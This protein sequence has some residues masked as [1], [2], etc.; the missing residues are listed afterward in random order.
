MR[1]NKA[2]LSFS[3]FAITDS[4]YRSV[5]TTSSELMKRIKWEMILQKKDKYCMAHNVLNEL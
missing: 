2:E 3:A 4:K 1:P 5:F